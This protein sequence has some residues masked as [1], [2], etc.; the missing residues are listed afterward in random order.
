M[1]IMATCFFQQRNK[2]SHSCSHSQQAWKGVRVHKRR[3]LTQLHWIGVLKEV[4]WNAMT[5]FTNQSHAQ[6]KGKVIRNAKK[7]QTNHVDGRQD[8]YSMHINNPCVRLFILAK[9]FAHT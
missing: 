4:K 6:K 2:R 3:R 9:S 5:M 8:E 7:R 1:E